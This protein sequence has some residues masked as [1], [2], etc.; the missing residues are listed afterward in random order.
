MHGGLG[1]LG[2]DRSYGAGA[3][4][5]A[6]GER[7]TGATLERPQFQPVVDVSC[8]VDIDPL[9]KSG[10]V[11]N[12]AGSRIWD[13]LTAPASEFDLVERLASAHV[14]IPRDRIAQDVASY[15]NSLKEQK[16]IDESG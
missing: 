13:S 7:F 4:A 14:A 5:R 8:Y 12:P 10:V 6:T 9:R 1:K 11:L 3:G 15:V 2:R 16:L